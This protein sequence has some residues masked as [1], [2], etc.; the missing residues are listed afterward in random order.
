VFM[1]LKVNVPVKLLVTLADATGCDAAIMIAP[2][3]FLTDA[4]EAPFG[5]ILRNLI[6]RRYS[7]IARR[8]R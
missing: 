7:N 1:A 3:G 5:R 2:A 6:E 8:R 4:Y